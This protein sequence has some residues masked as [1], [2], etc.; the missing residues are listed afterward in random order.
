MSEDNVVSLV[1][2]Y[3][4]PA[5]SPEPDISSEVARLEDV[6]RWVGDYLNEQQYQIT[7]GG[8]F[9]K[10]NVMEQQ[11]MVLRK[12]AVRYDIEFKKLNRML[13]PKEKIS[14]PTKF[15]LESAVDVRVE[16]DWKEWLAK[17][18]D[19][20]RFLPSETKLARLKKFVG[21]CKG[22][23]EVAD[24]D[25][26]LNVVA[27]WMWQVKRKMFGLSPKDHVMLV[28]SGKQGSGKSTAVNTL[29]SPLRE[30]RIDLNLE[31]LQDD[32]H[33][34]G[35]A[36]NFVVVC[37]EMQGCDKADIEALK[38]IITADQ[39]SARKLYTNTIDSVPQNVSFLGTSNKSLDVLVK[40]ETGMRRFFEM[41]CA[42][43]LAWDQINAIDP[44]ELWREIDENDPDGYVYRVQ[45]A[46][47]KAQ[48]DYRHKDPVESYLEETTALQGD[49]QR[50]TL[51]IDDVF[52]DFVKWCE[53]AKQRPYDK[54]YFSKR[55]RACGVEL[56]KVTAR[57]RGYTL[58]SSY[59]KWA[60]RSY[61]DIA[62]QLAEEAAKNPPDSQSSMAAAARSPVTSSPD[63]SSVQNVGPDDEMTQEIL[64]SVVG[65][66]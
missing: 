40:D 23:L 20:L 38:R 46:L 32:R 60:D 3:V 35:L 37:D 27:H 22:G 31:A 7:P 58:G 64:E 6:S 28:M 65:K 29:V 1:P 49:G 4:G 42:D 45:E 10:A 14:P 52:Q 15:V 43:K 55:M 26:S 33:Y 13:S 57:T 41:K 56:K 59:Q 9:S 8:Q 12:L 18:K 66:K 61:F 11:S 50:K 39:L 63:L 21:A 24:D 54:N 62:D 44:L 25:L 53:G 51:L 5:S 34:H 36:R 30:Y 19:Q 2:A 17:K 47:A 16:E 48:E